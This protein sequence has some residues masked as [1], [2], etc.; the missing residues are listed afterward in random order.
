MIDM[1]GTDAILRARP[2]NVRGVAWGQEEEGRRRGS[3]GLHV[4]SSSSARAGK[5]R[6][7]TERSRSPRR[8]GRKTPRTAA[9]SRTQRTARVEPGDSAL[10]K[11]CCDLLQEG[12]ALNLK[13][14]ASG[15]GASGKYSRT[16][17]QNLAMAALKI[18]DF[19]SGPCFAG[20]EYLAWSPP[21]SSTEKN[22]V[23]F[24]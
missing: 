4:R 19:Y 12:C 8:S 11:A 6:R 18:E 23:F 14:K 10:S 22:F 7:N 24:I 3:G 20:F 21:T 17:W 16:N 9:T 2:E 1:V 13:F 15:S 5:T